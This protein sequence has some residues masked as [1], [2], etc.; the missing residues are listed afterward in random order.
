LM[1]HFPFHPSHAPYDVVRTSREAAYPDTGLNPAPKRKFR[2]KVKFGGVP[3][4]SP[5]LVAYGSLPLGARSA[6]GD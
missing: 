5:K 6:E 4:I 1:V 2:W 3:W